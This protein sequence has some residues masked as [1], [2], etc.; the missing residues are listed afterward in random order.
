[1]PSGGWDCPGRPGQSSDRRYYPDRTDYERIVLANEA[2]LRLWSKQRR[3]LSELYALSLVE[4]EVARFYRQARRKFQDRIGGRIT[5][6]LGQGRI[7]QTDP[8]A[9]AA[10]LTGMVETFALRMHSDPPELEGPFRDAVLSVS[11]AWWR[12]VYASVA[13]EYAHPIEDCTP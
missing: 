2:Y 11:E 3:I 5:Y 7:P 6:L 12:S 10:L 4:P 8:T 13:P 9:L 1:M